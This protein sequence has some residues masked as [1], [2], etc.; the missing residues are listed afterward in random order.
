M[1]TDVTMQELESETAELL[2]NRETLNYCGRH[3]GSSNSFSFT[4]VVGSG[5]GNHDGNG[6]FLSPLSGSLDGNGNGNTIIVG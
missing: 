4:S 6:N 3:Q 1:S 2:P 5:N